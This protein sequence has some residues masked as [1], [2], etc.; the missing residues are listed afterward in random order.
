[1]GAENDPNK[2]R[3][4]IDRALSDA[5]SLEAINDYVQ[6]IA[7][8]CFIVAADNTPLAGRPVFGAGKFRNTRILFSS[9]AM[10]KISD[11]TSQLAKS[12][13]PTKLLSKPN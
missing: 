1:M 10:P 11:S 12:L 5:P 7:Q 6:L 13:W 8:K 2:P 4:D 3:V 9:I